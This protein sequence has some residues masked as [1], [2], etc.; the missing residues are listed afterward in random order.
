MANPF[1]SPMTIVASRPAFPTRD[2]PHSRTIIRFMEGGRETPSPP[3]ASIT[4]GDG[5]RLELPV[6]RCRPD[7]A[8]RWWYDL[9]LVLP[10]RLDDRRRGPSLVPRVVTICVPYPVV[11]PIP[12]E[13][14]R[15]LHPPPPEERQRWRLDHTSPEAPWAEFMVHRLDCARGLGDHLLTDLEALSQLA[16]PDP[17]IACPTCRPDLVLRQLPSQSA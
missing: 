11:Q 1:S 3:R 8:G 16:E 6:T 14:Y 9:E 4:L 12:G 10:D 5:Q 7:R 13:N 2:T 17:A 15:S